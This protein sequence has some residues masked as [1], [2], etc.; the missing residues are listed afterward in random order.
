[1]EKKPTYLMGEIFALPRSAKAYYPAYMK[2]SYSPGWQLSGLK[3]HPDVPR[4]WV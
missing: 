2:N 3:H 1:M 4:L